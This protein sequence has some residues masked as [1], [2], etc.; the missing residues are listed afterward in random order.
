[1]RLTA[2]TDLTPAVDDV[3][4]LRLGEVVLGCRVVEV[5]DGTVT[6]ELPDSELLPYGG[7][8]QGPLATHDAL[9]APRPLG[10]TVRT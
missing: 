7:S 8:R 4:F 1:M 2:S 9:A 3:V 10:P 6:F 5:A